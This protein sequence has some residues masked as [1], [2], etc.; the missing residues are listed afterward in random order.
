VDRF[1]ALLGHRIFAP[2]AAVVLAATVLLAALGTP[3]LWE[4]QELAVADHAVARNEPARPDPAASKPAPAA[5]CPKTAPSDD[6]A[7]TLTERAAATGQSSAGM[8]LPLALLGVLTVLAVFAIA[9]R[10]A[11]AR[12][13]L[14]ASLVCL[15]FP[16][17]VLQARQLTSELGTAAGATLLIFGLTHALRPWPGRWRTVDLSLSLLAIPVGGALAFYGG[18][19]LLGLLPPLLAVTAIAAGS[20][21]CFRRDRSAPGWSITGLLSIA[22][23]VSVVAVLAWQLYDLR[24]PIPGTRAL[25]GKSIVPADCWS[26]AL[27]G[28]WRFDDDLRTTYDS[29]FEQIAFGT[30]PWG[31]VAPLA[32]A[33]LLGSPEE[34]QR[35][36][37]VLTLGWAAASWIATAAFQRKVGFAIF[38]GFP[39][40]AVIIGLWLDNVVDAVTGERASSKRPNPHALGGLLVG[41]F[42]VLGALA[43]GKDLQTF[44]ERITSLLVGNDAVK[45][46]KNAV[47]FGVP[48][49]AY[50]LALG[51]AVAGSL[52]MTLWTWREPVSPMR[53]IWSRRALAACLGATVITCG[54]WPLWHLALSRNLSSKQVFSTYQELRKDGDALGIMGDMGNAPRYYT[55][56]NFEKLGNRDALLAF[57]K[58][59]E[60]VFALA[61]ASE[62]CAIHRG[63]MG[64]PY[65]VLDDTS[66]RTLLLSNRVDG[67]ADRNPLATAILRAEP[68]GIKTRPT[69]GRIIYDDKIELIGWT[70]RDRVGRGDEFEVTLYFKILKSVGGSW[71]IFAHFD[72]S[73]L[74]FQGDH[75]PINNRCQTS[76]WQ[77]GDYVVDRFQVDAGDATFNLGS[78]ELRI[79]FFTGSAPNWK[80]MKVSS[81][82]P[83]SLDSNDRVR[84]GAIILD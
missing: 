60:R 67:S 31:I 69:G 65:H 81:A 80:N 49:R 43:L 45:Y 76:F 61:P 72:G 25:A 39:A 18:G 32:I 36:A 30:F 14:L 58:R 66:A 10:F 1:F 71:K 19:A 48:L 26:T 21:L 63:A 8:R 41:L 56:G 27:G 35:R 16:L 68:A 15:S 11:G 83:G 24:D 59:P 62:L 2:C 70:M 29:V 44:P 50:L 47:L 17:L 33:I 4:P 77:E 73:G 6:G 13:G 20:G 38:A 22:A 55:D 74:R 52:A 57:L 46:P 64:Q 12:A 37:A 7:R 53:H 3:G 54:F 42:I 23:V 5:A 79:G 9:M 84:L 34:R 78:Y 51:V 40:L 28:L 75:D 82:P